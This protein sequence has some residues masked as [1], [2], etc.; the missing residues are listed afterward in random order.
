M[1]IKNTE[2]IVKKN[3]KICELKLNR[4][5]KSNAL[6][7]E[8]LVELTNKIQDDWRSQFTCSMFL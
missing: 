1:H 6:S 3:N 7:E 5:E 8:I 2:L 4:P